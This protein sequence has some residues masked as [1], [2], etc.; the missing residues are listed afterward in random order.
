MPAPALLTTASEEAAMA[1]FT[2]E[3]GLCCLDSLSRHLGQ[4]RSTV[5]CWLGGHRA[6]PGGLLLAVGDHLDPA[7]RAQLLQQLGARWGLAVAV[8]VLAVRPRAIVLA[9]LGA[10][11]LRV[12]AALLA[13]AQQEQL[14]PALVQL[15]ERV[16]EALAVLDEQRSA[17]RRA[18]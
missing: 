18:A 14:Q 12:L 5:S 11:A 2:L 13:G 3:N 16:P 1:R 10:A 8:S 15:G 7:G 9:E 17:R 4:A 6:P